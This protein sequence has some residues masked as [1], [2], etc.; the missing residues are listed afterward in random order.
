MIVLSPWLDKQRSLLSFFSSNLP[1]SL[2]R[3]SRPR[4]GVVG[5]LI[6]NRR[7]IQLQ[8]CALV[9]SLG[10]KPAFYTRHSGGRTFLNANPS[11]AE[12]SKF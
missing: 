7:W 2:R 10:L 8:Q 9:F 1:L 4:G 5:G 3:A 11:L 12:S 6:L